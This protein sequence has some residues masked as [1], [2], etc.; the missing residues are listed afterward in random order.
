[1]VEPTGGLQTGNGGKPELPI[2][3]KERQRKVNS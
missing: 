3:G 1:M 2:D